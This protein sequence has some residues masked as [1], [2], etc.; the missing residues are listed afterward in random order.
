MVYHCSLSDSKSPQFSRTRLSILADLNNAVVW[1]VFTRPLISKSSSPLTNP[2]VIVPRALISIGITVTFM[3]H[4]FFQIPSK[5]HL[6]IFLFAFLS[7]L[8]CDQPGQQSPQFGKFSC[9]LLLLLTISIF[10]IKWS[11]FISKSQRS[12]YVSFSR[13]NSELCI[14]HLFVWW[15]FLHD[16]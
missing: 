15:N 14:Y 4:S 16:S 9:F 10:E 11:I 6:F 2:L 12:F 1:M 3:F 5:V 7:V 8:L 13:I